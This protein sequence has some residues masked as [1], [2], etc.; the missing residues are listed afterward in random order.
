MRERGFEPLRFNPLDPKGIKHRKRDSIK[1]RAIPYN[2]FII[3]GFPV[4][5]VSVGIGP[6]RLHTDHHGHKTD[7]TET[8]C[9]GGVD[10]LSKSTLPALPEV[11]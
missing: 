8:L 10:Q 5:P 4:F 3:K 2:P 9:P 6:K 11:N 7:I 1:T